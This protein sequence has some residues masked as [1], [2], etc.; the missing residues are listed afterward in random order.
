M[1]KYANYSGCADAPSNRIHAQLALQL[2][3]EQTSEDVPRAYW[4]GTPPSGRAVF[5]H[6]PEWAP[7]YF[8]GW[9]ERYGDRTKGRL[10]RITANM[11]GRRDAGRIWFD[12]MDKFL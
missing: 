3:A 1:D 8:P 5:A 10:L 6:V 11:P 4:R 9:R 12:Y 7:R 2:D